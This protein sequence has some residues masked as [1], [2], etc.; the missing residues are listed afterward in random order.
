[1]KISKILIMA[2]GLCLITLLALPI[3]VGCG[4]GTI[5]IGISQ[6][7][8]HP[9]LDATR[10][11][12]IAGLADNGYVDGD[13]LIVDYQNSEGDPS[14]FGSIAQ[15]FVTNDV[16]IIVCIATPNAQA[17][18]AAAEGTDIPVVF[19]AVTDPVGSGIDAC[20]KVKAYK[21]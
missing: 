21:V 3:L 5:T 14:L 4:G 13:N 16:D 11:G 9:A 17:A 15:Q 8:T 20:V 1:M 7:A 6:V 2:I 19:T 18:I 12:I 10:E